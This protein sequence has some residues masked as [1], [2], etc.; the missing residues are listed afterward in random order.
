MVTI[1]NFV[2]IVFLLGFIIIA[3]LVL[4]KLAYATSFPKTICHHTPANDVTL[5]FQNQQSYNGHLGQPH[6]NSTYDTN[7]ACEQASPSPSVSPSPSASASAS[8][9]A[10]PSPSPSP[11]VSPSPS[12]S[13]SASPEPS[14][15]P[16]PSPSPRVTPTPTPTVSE[17]FSAPSPA[18]PPLYNGYTPA[19]L[20]L[21]W[22]EQGIPA[23]GKLF[24]K[25][26][27]EDK[28]IDT[29][30]IRYKQDGSLE[31]QY[32]VNGIPYKQGVYEIGNLDN[33]HYWFDIVGVESGGHGGKFYSE[34]FGA[35]D[36]L[37]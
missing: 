14:E 9:S 30:N 5:T 7:G 32:G 18:N 17:G 25:W 3:G 31:W 13:P 20:A 19:C 21:M 8:P 12:P 4:I 29:V 27:V 24:V 37:P 28:N 22:T 16:V 10:S 2:K 11:S 6:N 15:E 1:N 23:D 26:Y 33:V 34:C 35:V 36:P